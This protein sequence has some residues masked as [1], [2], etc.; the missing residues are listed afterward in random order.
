[1]TKLSLS[2]KTFFG[3]ISYVI[4]KRKWQD[5]YRL[6]RHVGGGSRLLQVLNFR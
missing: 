2:D 1:M 3:L 5:G 6:A 4:L